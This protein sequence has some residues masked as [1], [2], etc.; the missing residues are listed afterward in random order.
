MP[1]NTRRCTGFRPSRT[2]GNARPTMTDIA[3]L[4]VAGILF[5][6]DTAWFN[7]VTHQHREELIGRVGI[8]NINSDNEALRWIHRRVPELLG[9]HLAEALVARELNADFLREIERS[10]AQ[11]GE[12]LR[13][14]RLLAE[15]ERERRRP[16]H[17]YQLHVRLAKVQIDRRRKQLGEECDRLRRRR[18][19]L[20]HR[21]SAARLRACE[22]GGRVAVGG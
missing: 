22:H 7:L 10:G 8:F 11:L 21:F 1:Y 9:V 5:D 13:F 4:Y 3:H 17:L 20:Y 16:N 18:L 15:H 12:G 19:L 2:S 14:R 6:E